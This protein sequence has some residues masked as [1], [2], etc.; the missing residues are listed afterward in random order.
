MRKP[1]RILLILTIIALVG[2][3]ATLVLG[4]RLFQRTVPAVRL[5]YDVQEIGGGRLGDAQVA[6]MSDALQQR[7]DRQQMNEVQ[8]KPT[9]PKVEVLAPASV[10][11][12]DVKRVLAIGGM[13]SFHVV[14]EDPNEPGVAEMIARMEPG[15][16]GPKQQWGDK[17]RWFPCAQRNVSPVQATSGGINYILVHA[18]GDRAMTHFD[19]SQPWSV[20]NARATRD[21]SGGAAVAFELDRAGAKRF[22]DLTGSNTGRMLAIVL[23]G[24][25]LSAPRVNSR[26]GAHGIINGGPGGFTQ[27]E[28]DYLVS[29]LNAGS[30]PAKL[31]PVP[32]SEEY[33][34]TTLGLAPTARFF[35]KCAAATLAVVSLLLWLLRLFLRRF[36]PTVA[37]QQSTL[38]SQGLFDEP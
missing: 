24:N 29:T 8:V 21:Q 5:V 16:A 32:V 26:I 17:L 34:T 28:S 7:L 13:L 25:V 30:L 31:S 10:P 35:L 2:V 1:L 22:G 33:L 23:D 27:Q 20:K 11:K 14:I 12:G 6:D 15:G 3:L 37:D 9:G 19:T 18:T 4:D 36:H 38:R